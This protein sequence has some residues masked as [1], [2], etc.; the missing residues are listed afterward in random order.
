MFCHISVAFLLLACFD[1]LLLC[2]RNANRRR[3]CHVR[4][5]YKMIVITIIICALLPL[6]IPFTYNRVTATNTCAVDSNVGIF[7]VIYKLTVWA[8][9]PPSLMLILG[10]LT[11]YSLKQNARQ[12]V[13]TRVRILYEFQFIL[14]C[15]FLDSNS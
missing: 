2:S 8:I 5:A 15:F 13:H 6:Y 9:I 14:K 7:D 1:R 11:I 10:S 4:I 3:L 12:I